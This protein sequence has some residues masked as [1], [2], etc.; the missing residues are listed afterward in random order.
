MQIYYSF[1]G[2]DNPLLYKSEEQQLL[3]CHNRHPILLAP[4]LILWAV[5]VMTYDRLLLALMLPLYM[6]LGSNV[7]SMDVA[8]VSQQLKM[9]KL[10]L[11][12]NH[13]KQY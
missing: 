12:K 9:K 11:L 2:F 8:Y 5:P 7:D 10:Q 3:L 4:A 1:Y 6:G 13:T